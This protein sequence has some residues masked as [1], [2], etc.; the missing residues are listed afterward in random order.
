MTTAEDS[1][2]AAYQTVTALEDDQ[3]AQGALEQRVR[4]RTRELEAA[5]ETL[6]YEAAERKR[7]EAADE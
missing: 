2:G 4:E 6:R 3:T 1:A 5:A 7:T